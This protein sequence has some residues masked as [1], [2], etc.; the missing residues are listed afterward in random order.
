MRASV[1][2]VAIAALPLAGCLDA[3]V[4]TPEAP[5][6]LATPGGCSPAHRA[7]PHVD[8]SVESQRLVVD[9][10][11]GPGGT[12]GELDAAAYPLP[13]EGILAL[14]VTPRDC[15][16]DVACGDDWATAVRL[17]CKR[18]FAALDGQ[19]ELAVTA[20]ADGPDFA[21][22]YFTGMQ[23]DPRYDFVHR[24]AHVLDARREGQELVLRLLLPVPERCLVLISATHV[25]DDETTLW[26]QIRTRVEALPCTGEAE[27]VE[28]RPTGGK[29]ATGVLSYDGQRHELLAP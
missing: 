25:R 12:C 10:F 1:A 11:E 3:R 26:P 16:G 27:E 28:L 20:D 4:L 5:P 24:V 8:W 21:N 14:T 18:P 29:D 2:L 9:L 17:T 7:P 15:G 6:V 23:L 19:P 13:D 22:V